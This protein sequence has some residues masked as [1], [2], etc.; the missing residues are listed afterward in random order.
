MSCWISK[1]TVVLLSQRD[2]QNNLRVLEGIMLD[3]IP[4]SSTA[5]QLLYGPVN[6]QTHIDLLPH[7]HRHHSDVILFCC[8][9]LFIFQ[10]ASR[11]IFGFTEPQQSFLFVLHGHVGL[12]KHQQVFAVEVWINWIQIITQLC[13]ISAF[14]ETIQSFSVLKWEV[15]PSS[16]FRKNSKAWKW[17]KI[18]F[19]SKCGTTVVHS[20]NQAEE[21][22]NNSGRSSALT[23]SYVEVGGDEKMMAATFRWYHGSS[24]KAKHLRD[25][26]SP[27]DLTCYWQAVG[28]IINAPCFSK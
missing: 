1:K 28:K 19:S 21:M 7:S 16:A 8:V 23:S 6:T 2:L 4:A 26:D 18:R 20:Q 9:H 5:Q 24:A 13:S 10:C 22:R 27:K 25:T 3:F 17:Q 12:P 15:S 11:V 14:K